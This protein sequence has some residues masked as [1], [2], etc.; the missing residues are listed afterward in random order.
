[1]NKSTL[2]QDFV[3]GGW[4]FSVIGGIGMLI[5]FLSGNI[6]FIS[7][8][9]FFMKI[10]SSM[11]LTSVF[12]AL[13]EPREEIYSWVKAIA[14][15]LAGLIGPELVKGIVALGGKFAS[16]PLQVVKDLKKDE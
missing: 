9:D 3:N 1:M 12:W 16:D 8:A 15:G 7:F 13:L 6:K 5:R 10:T 4:I 11:L 14:Y 2:I